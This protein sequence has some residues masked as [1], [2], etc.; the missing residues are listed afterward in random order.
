MRTGPL[1]ALRVI[2]LAGI[3]PAPFCGMLLA[4]L[5]ADVVRIERT[6]ANPAD[7]LPAGCLLRNRRSIALNFKHPDAVE[8]L[9]KLAGTADVLIE[10]YRPGV[11]ERLGVGPDACLARNPKLVYGRMTGWGQEGPLAR[12]AGHDINYIAL[13]GALHMIG[14][15][16]GKPIPPLNLV[17]DFGGGGM[18]LAFGVLAGV[19]EAGRSGRGQ[20][21]DAAMI[22]GTAAMM[23]VF[24]ALHAQGRVRDATGE[25]MLAGAAP[26][27]D[28]YRTKDGR[29]VAI[30][31][32]EP[33]FFSLLLEKLGLDASRFA[34]T[35]YPAVGE[36]A[37]RRWPALRAA[38]TEAFASRTRDEWCGLLEGADACFAPVL[39][40]GEAPD[41][42]H[43][44]ARG[45]FIEVDGVPQSAPAPRFSRTPAGD[46]RP[47]A[48]AGEHTHAVLAEAGYSTADIDRLRAAGALA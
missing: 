42:P 9:L 27:Y 21:V 37:R 5:G 14:T 26:W 16:G 33:Q 22:D 28:T 46:V 38:L 47:A 29:Y 36:E 48:S 45:T 44:R 40:L 23:S 17:G 35:G 4:D 6:P 32:I 24:F 34:G 11:T 31:A 18:L 25:D 43:H 13:S 20:V 30:G 10:G 8:V 3:G 2:E 39:S 12:S 41:H 7:A 1:T 19:I 15:A